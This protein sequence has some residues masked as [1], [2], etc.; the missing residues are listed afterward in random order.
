[1]NLF[2]RFVLPILFLVVTFWPDYGLAYWA[3]GFFPAYPYAVGI[4]AALWAIVFS[5]LLPLPVR[6][7]RTVSTVLVVSAIVVATVAAFAAGILPP[8]T[9]QIGII[10]AIVFAGI[11]LGWLMVSTRI[12]RGIHSII[13]VEDQHA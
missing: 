11:V 2:W 1:M 3:W 8:F 6:M 4:V 13:A 12:W 9:V 7:F 10:Y 5:L